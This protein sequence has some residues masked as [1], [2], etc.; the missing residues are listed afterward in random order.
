LKSRLA[1]FAKAPS[2]FKAGTEHSA[3][4]VAS[5]RQGRDVR[6]K[7][8]SLGI[9]MNAGFKG[10]VMAKDK[11]VTVT[12]ADGLQFHIVTPSLARLQKLEEEWEK[13]VK[14]NPSDARVAAYVD[15]SVANL[16]SLAVVAE[17]QGKSILLT[18]DAR[19]DDLLEGLA[20]AGFITD[21]T[22][23]ECHFDILKMPHHGSNRNMEKDFLKRITADHYVISADG[24][25]SNP[26]ADTV[27]WI[28]EARGSDSYKVYI[29][30]EKLIEPKT[31]TDIGAV[32]KKVLK[33][34][35]M[36]K[37]TVFRKDGELGVTVNLFDK[38]TV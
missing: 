16:S 1:A 30:N 32:V 5:V 10:L 36:E 21:A 18:G 22:T 2:G 23:G 20:S 38:L 33:E 4:V 15:K 14:K 12:Q 31:K 25:H 17:F 37:K 7:A 11:R 19:G 27:S 28:G 3:A 24:K 26:D 34:Q 8:E 29:T 9:V 13:D 35:G 6:A